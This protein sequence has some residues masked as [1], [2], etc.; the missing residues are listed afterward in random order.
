M[1]RRDL[2][3]RDLDNHRFRNH[4]KQSDVMTAPS[5]NFRF[6][7]AGGI[8][9]VASLQPGSNQQHDSART[10]RVC[11][12]R[13]TERHNAMKVITRQHDFR[14]RFHRR[15]WD[16]PIQRSHEQYVRG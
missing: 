14:Q 10:P 16:L 5:R 11:W 15:R 12:R 7:L 13:H 9:T 6:R 8:Y 3:P 2:I 1:G 4:Y